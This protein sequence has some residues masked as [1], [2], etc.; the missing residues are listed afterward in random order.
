METPGDRCSIC[1][2]L[3]CWCGGMPPDTDPTGS[4]KALERFDDSDPNPHELAKALAR[5]VRVL[6]PRLTEWDAGP[7][8]KGIYIE[9]CWVEIRVTPMNAVS[10]RSM[11]SD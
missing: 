1:G 6:M 8:A 9:G 4:L 7:V 10:G 2:H 11:M 3:K 5:A